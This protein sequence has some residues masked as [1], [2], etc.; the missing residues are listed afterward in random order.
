LKTE[1]KTD[2]TQ[3]VNEMTKFESTIAILE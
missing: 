3:G 2:G 1:N